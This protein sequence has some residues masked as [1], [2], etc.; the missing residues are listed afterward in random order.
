[1]FQMVKDLI[2]EGTRNEQLI[3]QLL[4]Q[5]VANHIMKTIRPP[6]IKNER[7]IPIWMLESIE[8]FI[9]RSAWQYIRQSEEKRRIFKEI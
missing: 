4:P 7:E 9:V 8:K 6:V 3:L 5:E 2:K 1:M